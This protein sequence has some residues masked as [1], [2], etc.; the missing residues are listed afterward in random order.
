[1]NT[2]EKLKIALRYYLIGREYFRAADALEFAAEY[3]DGLRKDNVTPE[4]QHQIEITHYLR[5]LP[6]LSQPENTLIAGILH[7]TRE[8]Y[9]VSDNMIRM[10]FGD[11]VADACELLNKNGKTSE[12]YFDA[13]ASNE[14]ASIVKGGDRINNLQSMVGVFTIEKQLKY[15]VEVEHYFLPMLKKA[16]RNFARQEPAYENIKFMLTSQLELLKVINNQQ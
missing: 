12:G 9:D 1:M 14:I 13:I 7:D 10:R 15:I 2:Y 4:F 6:S 3:H 16:R 8:D 11:D 5:T